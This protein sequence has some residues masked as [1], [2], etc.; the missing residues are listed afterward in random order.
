MRP[1]AQ[2]RLSRRQMRFILV[3]GRTPCP[4]SLCALCRRPIRATYLREVN[5]R[6]SYCDETCY[7]EHCADAMLAIEGYA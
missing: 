4:R 1:S 2:H 7:A 6:L 3:N 5:T